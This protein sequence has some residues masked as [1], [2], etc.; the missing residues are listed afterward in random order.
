[1]ARQ[2]PLD[3]RYRPALEREVFLVAPGNATAIEWID[4]WPAWP[5]PAL[6]LQGPRGSGKTHLASVWRARSGGWEIPAAALTA[7]AVPGL[8]AQGVR[9]VV[10]GAEVAPEE[11]LLHLYNAITERGG[12]LLLTAE[13]APAQWTTALP[14]L[15]SR[16]RALPIASLALP[17]DG[18][19]RAVLAK[20]FLDRRLRVPPDVLDFLTIRLERSFEA[21]GSIVDRLDRAAFADKRRITVPFARAVLQDG[22]DPVP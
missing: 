7:A 8:L 13:R 1:M 18:L 6:V 17:D 3:L 2:L 11:P 9:G 21:A 22:A 20:L 12:H 14:D 16:L 5:V 10:D 4:R 19:F 15:R